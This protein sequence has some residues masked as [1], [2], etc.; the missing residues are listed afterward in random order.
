QAPLVLFV[1]F[2]GWWLVRYAMKPR[3]SIRCGK[4]VDEQPGCSWM[5]RVRA[6]PEEAVFAL[7]PLVAHAGII[8]RTA[9]GGAAKF[10]EHLGRTSVRK[11]RA[12][13]EPGG[14]RAQDGEV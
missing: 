7:Y 2:L 8:G 11:A 12:D 5:V 9:S 13:L 6:R 10:V 14:E 3:T 1:S 4:S